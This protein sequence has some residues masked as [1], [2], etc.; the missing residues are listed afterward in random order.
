MK[1]MNTQIHTDGN[2]TMHIEEEKYPEIYKILYPAVM[3]AI[4]DMENRYGNIKM[5]DE[6]LNAMV[7]RILE[8]S[9]LLNQAPQPMTPPEDMPEAVPA[10][11]IYGESPRR[12][13]HRHNHWG[14]DGRGWD[15]NNWGW[16]HH[17]RSTLNDITQILLLNQI[18]GGRRPR[19]LW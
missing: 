15:G 13:E 3:Q 16:R 19:W 2:F 4:P 18:F 7:D 9:G 12:G 10:A 11:A 5:T 14:W 8:K 17:N 6:V 1:G